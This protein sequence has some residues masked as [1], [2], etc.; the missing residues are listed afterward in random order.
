M[1]FLMPS[2]EL[3]EPCQPGSNSEIVLYHLRDNRDLSYIPACK[4]YPQA[5]CFASL[6]DF[7]IT[8]PAGKVLIVCI[9][10]HPVGSIHP[11]W[12]VLILVK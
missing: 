1:C 4:C 12:L 2:K 6:L 9:Q 10:S 7:P 5:P 11:N 8:H 3:S